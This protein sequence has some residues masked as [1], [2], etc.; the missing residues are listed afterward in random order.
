M[1]KICDLDL[2]PC[3]GCNY[4]CFDQYSHCPIQDDTATVYEK[5][6]ESDLVIIAVP[7]YSSA[8]PASYF[9][10]RER[11]Q[12]IFTH[13]DQYENFE[14]VVKGYIVFGNEEAG[15]REVVNFLQQDS[16]K[17]LEYLMLQSHEYDQSSIEG[18]LV[19]ITE[20]REKLLTFTKELIDKTGLDKS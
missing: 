15:G 2:G 4:E 20:V 14:K 6:L 19:E 17:P 9:A 5:I 8:P 18:N 10:W 3:T 16:E 7:T 12:G 11:S 1:I 13:N